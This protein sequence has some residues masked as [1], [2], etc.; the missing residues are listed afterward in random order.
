LP[1][2]YDTYT[3]GVR[4]ETLEHGIYANK[5]CEPDL[6]ATQLADAVVRVLRD[7]EGEEGHHIRMRARELARLCQARRGDVV[8]ADAILAVA[9]GS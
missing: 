9:S 3:L 8:A 1:Q 7:R 4:V 6:D 5:G 2:W